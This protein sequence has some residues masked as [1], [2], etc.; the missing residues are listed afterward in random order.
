MHGIYK[1]ARAM[2]NILQ[3]QKLQQL[4]D[5]LHINYTTYDHVPV[6][7]LDDTEHESLRGIPGIRAKS[8]LCKDDNDHIWMVI[9][10][11]SQRVDMKSVSKLLQAPNL[12]FVTAEQLLH[13]LQVYMHLV[14][15][16][17][18]SI[19]RLCQQ[20]LLGFIRLI[21]VRQP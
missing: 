8:L 14:L 6:F 17:L 19:K 3:Y 18:S 7:T 15:F 11:G 12:R 2:Q 10:S 21:T 13:L 4:L 9:A 16:A 1:K 5:S 20:I